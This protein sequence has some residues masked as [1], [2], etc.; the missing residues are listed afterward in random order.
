MNEKI[1][2]GSSV[3]EIFKMLET[4]SAFDACT[5]LSDIFNPSP[6]AQRLQEVMAVAD[7]PKRKDDIDRIFGDHLA[8][9][10][11]AEQEEFQLNIERARFDRIEREEMARLSARAKWETSQQSPAPLGTT[12]AKGAPATQGNIMKK[13]ALIAAL[14]HEWPSIEADIS[15]ATRNGLKAVGHAGEHGDWDKD[16]AR[17][18]AVSKG[19]IKQTASVHSL[20]GAWPG[21]TTRHTINR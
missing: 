18:W 5:P 21:A 10:V 11:R 19:K 12:S 8:R 14:E 15:E 13:K 9:Q 6:A 3:S 17:A 20:V 4:P 1:T 16:K 7:S 2:T